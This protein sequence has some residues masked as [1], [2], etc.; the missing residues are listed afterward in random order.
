MTA[1]VQGRQILGLK[2]GKKSKPSPVFP[3]TTKGGPFKK[4][5]N[6]GDHSSASSSKLADIV[7]CA[8]QTAA[9]IDQHMKAIAQ[10]PPPSPPADPKTQR[11]CSMTDYIIYSEYLQLDCDTYDDV[12]AQLMLFFL[13]LKAQVRR[14]KQHQQ[15]QQCKNHCPLTLHQTQG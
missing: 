5:K 6:T 7:Q 13:Q 11:I 10:P 12:E 15:Q 1:Q 3:A 9:R 14:K 2:N 8:Q 4:R